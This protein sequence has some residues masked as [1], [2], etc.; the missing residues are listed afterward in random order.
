MTE[1]YGFELVREEHIAE[2][3]TRARLYRHQQTGAELL[4]L[5][6]DDENKVFGITFRTPPADSTGLPH[7]MEH[8]VLCGS[9]K[10]PVKE[11]FVELIKGSLNTFLNAMTFS[12]KT[13]Y[14]VASQNLQDFY[15]L[16]D[17]YLDAVFFP[18]LT[19][20]TLMQEGWHYELDDPTKPMTYKGVVFNEMKGAYSQPENILGDHIESSLFPDNAYRHDSGGNPS[21]IPD[22]TFEQFQ[23]FHETFYHPSNSRIFF[24]GDDDP[25]QRLIVVNE[26][27]HLFEAIPV[28]SQ[29]EIQPSFN[30][31]RREEVPY[32]VAADKQDAKAFVTVNWLLP[33]AGDPELTLGLAVLEQVLIG[34]PAAQLRKALIDSGLG[35]DL[36]GAGLETGVRQMYFSTGIK[37]VD[38]Q[39]VDQAEQLILDTISSIAAQGVD[40]ENVAAALNTLEF[41]LRENNTGAY[42]RGLVVMIRALEFWLYDKDPLA[43]LAFEAPLNAVKERLASGEPYL[44][45]LIE[46]YL[47]DNNHRTTVVLKPDQELS[48]RRAAAERTQLDQA[49]A[50][51]GEEEVN[52]VIE[53][54]AELVDRQ[55]TPDSP[56]ALMTIPMLERDDLDREIRRIPIDVL[57]SGEN[58]ILYHDLFTNGILY[59][60]LG[61]NMR[62]LAQDQVPYLPLFSRALLETGTQSESFVQLLQRIGRTTGGVRPSTLTSAV[63]GSDEPVA[64]LFLRGK[65]MAN[66][67][68]DLLAVLKDILTG[69]RLED[70]DRFRQMALEEKARLESRLIN[71]GHAVVNSRLRA[72]FTLADWASEQMGGIS[73]LFFLRKL[74]QQV[75]QDWPSVQSMLFNMR[76]SMLTGSNAL[77][78]ITLD[79]ENWQGIRG[80]IEEFLSGLPSRPVELRQWDLDKLPESEGLTIPAQVNYVGKGAN[81]YKL[82]Y[83]LHGSAFVINNHLNGSW[84][85]DKIRVQGGA[86]GGFSVF[87]N[88]SGVFN[89]LSYRDPNL[90]QSLEIYDRTSEYLKKLDLSESELTKAIIGTI[91][92][93][94]SYQLPDAKGFTSMRFY[95]L[96]LGDEERQRIRDEVLNTTEEDFK[97]FGETLEKIKDNGAV[98]VLGVDEALRAAGIFKD[99]QR[100]L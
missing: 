83:K 88:Q 82:G 44:E 23:A 63:R 28:D 98:V 40:K 75:D 31:P 24:Y 36:T 56:E 57:Q 46:E 62:A 9:R 37:G 96:G 30:E 53:N 43:P 41:R 92:D 8:S 87:D 79:S 81:L 68:G 69:A 38:P 39:N 12:D 17:V 66:Q 21:V 91:G 16:V 51:M 5:E 7:I 32:E 58:K 76:D 64:W 72:R 52:Q 22:L 15:N 95:L 54:M 100:V 11:P 10:Y 3:N 13:C 47:I 18:R 20:Y 1:T 33:E 80:Q 73:Y 93:L 19:P 86:Y 42:P 45:H 34:N 35:E 78:N 55:E 74:V 2:L 61:F 77:L 90:I 67:T 48:A 70:R 27:L 6:N 94:D 29:V 99:I 85:W 49:R 89:F 84:M 59:L 4:S 26:Y 71:A 97:R 65:A 60:D 25:E 14:P 50:E